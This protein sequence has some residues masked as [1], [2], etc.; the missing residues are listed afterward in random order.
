MLRG[1]ISL[2][3]IDYVFDALKNGEWH[4][5]N[6]ISEK[7]RLPKLKIELLTSFLAEYDF[8]EVDKKEQKTRLTPPLLRFIKKIQSV[9]K[10]G[11][12]VRRSL[13][14]SSEKET[15]FSNSFLREQAFE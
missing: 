1:K 3:I 9:E 11:G 14:R 6:E 4:N 15:N 10:K 2:P 12:T 8:V 13:G 5:L 7:T